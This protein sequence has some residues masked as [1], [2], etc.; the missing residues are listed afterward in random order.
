MRKRCQWHA[1][2]HHIYCILYVS[3]S[4]SWTLPA[5]YTLIS[6]TCKS[7]AIIESP[8]ALRVVYSV[9]RFFFFAQNGAEFYSVKLKTVVLS[10]Y[11]ITTA[12]WMIDCLFMWPYYIISRPLGEWINGPGEAADWG[13]GCGDV[14]ACSHSEPA[15]VFINHACH[16][17]WMPMSVPALYPLCWGVNLISQELHDARELRSSEGGQGCFM[18]LWNYCGINSTSGPHQ[19]L[20]WAS[21]TPRAT[22]QCP[23]LDE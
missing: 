9:L 3:V 22:G 10:H 5:L 15:L 1:A 16:Q 7:T 20:Q 2:V 13:G 21:Y 8:V 23:V 14:L 6:Q 19:L 18:S 11:I 4:A 17:F 12:P